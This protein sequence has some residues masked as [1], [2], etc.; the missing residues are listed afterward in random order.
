M[1]F[2]SS[3]F[4]LTGNNNNNKFLRRGAAPS[5]MRIAASP[6]RTDRGSIS[7]A[8]AITDRPLWGVYASLAFHKNQRL[9][10]LM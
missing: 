6:G 5:L 3:E 10:G 8:S 1:F 7:A 2:L 9:G 4:V